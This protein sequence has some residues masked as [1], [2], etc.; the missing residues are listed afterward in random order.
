[1]GRLV[2]M[3]CTEYCV[4]IPGVSLVAELLLGQQMRLPGKT[5]PKPS[6][7]LAGYTL[8]VQKALAERLEAQALH[9]RR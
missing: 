7:Q 8:D 4:V 3:L 1:M 2:T 9:F 6:V 5:Q